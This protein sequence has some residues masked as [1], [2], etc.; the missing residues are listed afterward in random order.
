MEGVVLAHNKRVMAYL[1]ILKDCEVLSLQG[2]N[3]AVVT[4]DHLGVGLKKLVQL[5]RPLRI[6]GGVKE[7][8]EG[9]H[10]GMVGEAGSEA[11]LHTA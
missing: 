1:V 2:A 5:V 6:A 8:V 10:E 3:L 4:Q 11:P 7:Y 9:V